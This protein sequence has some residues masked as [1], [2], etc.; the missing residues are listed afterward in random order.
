[1]PHFA[2]QENSNQQP[3]RSLRAS[4]YRKV[5]KRRRGDVQDDSSSPESEAGT[6]SRSRAQLYTSHASPEIAQL[7]VAGLLPEEESEIP[8]KPFPHAPV[9]LVK[10][11]CGPG[12]IQEEIAKS[13]TRLY[14]VNG[15]SKTNSLNKQ[16]ATTS[17]KYSHLN[18]LS[19]VMHRCLLDG[20][21]QRAGRAWG[22]L[23]RTQIA[24]G[25]PV[26]PRNHERW[27]IGA[28]IILCR[29][30]GPTSDDNQQDVDVELFSD[31]GFE[32]ARE[33]YERII[34][35]YPY[36]T[37][38]PHSVDERSF[39][40]AMFSLWLFEVNE[41]SKRAMQQ[42]RDDTARRS[43]SVSLNSVTDDTTT[44][45]RARE[46]AIQVE[47]L[48]GAL[49][50]A[51]RLDQLVASPPFDKQA[52]LLDIRGQICL[53]ISVLL[54][55]RFEDEEDWDMDTT[56]R[57]LESSASVE[58]QLNRI[59]NTKRGLLQAQHFFVRAEANGATHSSSAAASIDN[60]LKELER[61]AARFQA[62]DED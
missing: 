25:R 46:D 45:T 50:I 8:P 10:E 2:P 33:Y 16:S 34:V 27:G 6:T 38:S 17:L 61:R 60:K 7:R 35:Q 53:W 26:D 29:R 54:E 58:Q 39:Y 42:V 18:N 15:L 41:K 1:M 55:G 30:A 49:E 14:A 19:T 37:L 31:E 47:E 9:R 12:K 57:S 62:D 21:Y 24:G 11:R 52:N 23:L 28:E 5:K 22:I 40:P 43:R 56:D 4:Q 48:A 20:D 44:D 51:E 13:P 3:A 36:R 32:L 59:N